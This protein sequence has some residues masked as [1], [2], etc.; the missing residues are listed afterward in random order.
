MTGSSVAGSSTYR[1]VTP[2][3]AKF[4]ANPDLFAQPD[5]LDD[6]R[7]HTAGI[8]KIEGDRLTLYTDVPSAP[9]V[10]ELPHVFDLAIAHWCEYFHVD[11]ATVR[12]WK[13]IGSLIDR[14]ERFQATGMLPD[15]L[16]EFLNGYQRGHH[17]WL[18]DQP[19]AYYRRHL[20]LHEGTHAFM[21]WFLEGM[22]PPW[23]SEGM[24][25]LLA[26]HLWQDGTLQLAYFPKHRDE[27]D[28]WGRIKMVQTEF[29]AQRGMSLEQIASYGPRDHLRNEPYG[30]CW[31]AQRVSG[32]SSRILPSLSRTPLTRS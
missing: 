4:E 31:A 25:E 30:W 13:M 27:V 16:P 17:L 15:D 19:S 26:T 11:P 9:E 29:A 6:E 21:Q 10:D 28:H 12:S 3:P 23:Y 18:Y 5:P 1:Q 24:A 8:R 14:R 2:A 22:G 32:R 20:L 7:L